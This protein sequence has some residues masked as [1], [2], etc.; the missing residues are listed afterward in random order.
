MIYPVKNTAQAELLKD[1]S[2]DFTIPSLLQ[3]WDKGEMSVNEN[4]CK[5]PLSRPVVLLM[6]QHGRNSLWLSYNL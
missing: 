3:H 4:Y 5:L 6:P 2:P 1:S